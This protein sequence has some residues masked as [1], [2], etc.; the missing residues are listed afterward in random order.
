MI[1]E[2]NAHRIPERTK[3]QSSNSVSRVHLSMQRI[4]VRDE[5]A[6]EEAVRVAERTTG[7]RSERRHRDTKIRRD[8]G[9]WN[10]A[11][12]PG[13][14]GERTGGRGG[15]GE[16]GRGRL[17]VDSGARSS[18][19]FI[20]R[21]MR[22]KK[23]TTMELAQSEGRLPPL[24]R[25]SHSLSHSARAIHERAGWLIIA[26]TTPNV[27]GAAETNQGRRHVKCS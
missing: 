22:G 12:R 14:R 10:V 26:H 18:E 7:R 3:G 5:M 2:R 11:P 17:Y 1:H 19:L 16:R 15:G 27:T 23:M 8:C 21:A 6:C 25:V 13:S 24:I 9:M 4:R 20:P